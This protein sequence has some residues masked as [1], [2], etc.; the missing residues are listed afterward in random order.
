MVCQGRG[1]EVCEFLLDLGDFLVDVIVDLVSEGVLLHVFDLGLEE[2]AHFDGQVV[3]E[4]VGLVVENGVAPDFPHIG[5]E[6]QRRLVGP[7]PQLLLDPAQV[8][9]LLHDL[10]VVR[11]A[12]RREVHRLEERVGGVVPLQLAQHFEALL[13]HVRGV[14][15]ELRKRVQLPEPVLFARPDPPL[16][17]F[18]ELGDNRLDLVRARLR[19]SGFYCA[20]AGKSS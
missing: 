11:N 1:L 7:G 20:P 15:V 13:H 12:Q 5:R 9:G 2:V 17:L 16:R 10:G 6:L 18:L 14:L 3:D 8:H 4:G 19:S